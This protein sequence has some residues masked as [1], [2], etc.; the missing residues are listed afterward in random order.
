MENFGA[1]NC[2][3]YVVIIM[4]RCAQIALAIVLSTYFQQYAISVLT[5]EKEMAIRQ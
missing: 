4:N 5:I 1:F 2:D 3:A